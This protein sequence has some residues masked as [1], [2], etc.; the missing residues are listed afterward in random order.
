MYIYMRVY[1]YVYINSGKRPAKD[2]GVRDHEAQNTKILILNT[3][4]VFSYICIYIYIYM[5]SYTFNVYIYIY[6]YTY[7]YVYIYM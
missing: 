3:I 1:T 4:C 7:V 2:R 6:T 5:C